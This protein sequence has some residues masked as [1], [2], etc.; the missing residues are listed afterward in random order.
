MNTT[1]IGF[2]KY[3]NLIFLL[4]YK[5]SV[6]ALKRDTWPTFGKSALNK[7]VKKI[8]IVKIIQKLFKQKLEGNT[9]Y[10]S[11]KNI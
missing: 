10:K 2:Q 6:M 8:T 7:A 1:S 9:K 4:N 5:I 3:F 11:Q